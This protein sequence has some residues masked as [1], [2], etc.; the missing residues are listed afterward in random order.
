M[1]SEPVQPTVASLLLFSGTLT[2]L[3]PRRAVLWSLVLGL[4][5]PV[6]HA[7]AR[8]RGTALPYDVDGYASTFLAL[9]PAGLGSAA[10]FALRRTL[11][12]RS[13]SNPAD[14]A[15]GIR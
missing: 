11:G 4:S 1:H 3:D 14:R 10:G 15:G 12:P 8:V 13:R 2:W 6:A 5:I 9:L 7:L